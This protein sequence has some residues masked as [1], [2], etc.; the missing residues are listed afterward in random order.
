MKKPKQNGIELHLEQE[1]NESFEHFQKSNSKFTK[2]NEDRKNS[3]E[4]TLFLV[5]WG[6]ELWLAKKSGFR[7]A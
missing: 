1:L 5:A 6:V 4:R 2:K 7:G 3:A